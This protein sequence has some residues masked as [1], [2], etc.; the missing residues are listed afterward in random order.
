MLVGGTLVILI[1]AAALNALMYLLSIYFQDP[2]TLALSPL[3]AGV[4]TLPATLAMLAITPLVSPLAIRLG[5]RQIIGLGFILMAA[6]F[7]ALTFVH[8]S[9][10]YGM[11]VLPLVLM[12][13]GM[14]LT[15]GPASSV[16]TSAVDERDVGAASGVSNMARYVG[17]A[18]ATAAAA[19]V[20]ADV[21]AA[22]I[23]AGDPPGDALAEGLSRA[24]LLLT[25][26]SASGI[27]LALLA[28]RHRPTSQTLNDVAA[29]AAAAVHT[30]P[31][32][33]TA[34]P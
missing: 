5:T 27:L 4:A 23:A 34:I 7:G 9:W 10:A 29:D 13:V 16:C 30:T 6:G 8:A 17:A 26:L 14:G 33:S 20:Y 11:F 1:G 12:A 24:S 19:A 15:N 32:T 3:R 31:R 25:I 22:A 2:N 18:M 21:S 28:R